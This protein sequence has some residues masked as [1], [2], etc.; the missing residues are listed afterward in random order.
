[1]MACWV[2]WHVPQSHLSGVYLS[3]MPASAKQGEFENN[4]KAKIQEPGERK[5]PPGP[6][7]AHLYRQ[8]AGR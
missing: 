2:W 6:A 1:M 3:S 4:L 7:E 5:H 8:A